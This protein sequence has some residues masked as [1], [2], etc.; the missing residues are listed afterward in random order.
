MI[1]AAYI[2]IFYDLPHCS[3]PINMH[4]RTHAQLFFYLLSLQVQFCQCYQSNIVGPETQ[5][6]LSVV[7]RWWLA[8]ERGGHMQTG[9][10]NCKPNPTLPPSNPF[11]SFYLTLV[12]FFP[13]PIVS[14]PPRSNLVSSLCLCLFI[15]GL[16]RL[17]GWSFWCGEALWSTT[18]PG[19]I[20]S[21]TLWR[22]QWTPHCFALR[23]LLGVSVVMIQE[24]QE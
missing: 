6:H 14:P 3:T 17:P 18:G 8:S 10:Y 1:W 21:Q 23:E 7:W 11:S 24:G 19:E 12:L 22:P 13:L 5:S 16:R 15:S 20:S 9:M 2:P 4:A